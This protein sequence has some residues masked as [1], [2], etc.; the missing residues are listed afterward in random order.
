MSD[1]NDNIGMLTVEDALLSKVKYDVPT[2]AMRTILIDRELDGGEDYASCDRDKA[3]LAYA[4]LLK[5]MILGPGK[6]NNTTDSDNGW[7]H[8][9]GG[10]ELTEEDIQR[11][12][13]EADAI[14]KELEPA[15]C[16]K[17][18]STFRITSHGVKR[19]NMDESGTWMPHVIRG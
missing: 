1:V 18:R 6:V 10:Y 3:R 2:E 11:L 13:A 4:D 19:A 8:A 9:G 5:W 12:R 15:S 14:Y 16:L 17:K 7:S